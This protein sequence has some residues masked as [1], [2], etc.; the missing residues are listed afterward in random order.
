VATKANVL[1]NGMTV[2]TFNNIPS[3]KWTSLISNA[4][5]INF[6]IGYY[7]DS[8][9]ISDTVSIDTISIRT[10]MRGA[11]WCT[12]DIEAEY[13]YRDDKVTVTIYTSG[14]FKVNY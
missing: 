6:R 8:S 14:T 11:W 12:D 10:D 5:D 1:A 7:M 9:N 2:N 13:K 4:G 3:Y